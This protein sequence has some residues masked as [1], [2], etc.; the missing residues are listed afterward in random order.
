MPKTVLSW[1]G[2]SQEAIESSAYHVSGDIMLFSF[3]SRMFPL[4]RRMK[5]KDKDG[6]PF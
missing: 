3:S 1:R 4:E 6:K 2:E 5:M